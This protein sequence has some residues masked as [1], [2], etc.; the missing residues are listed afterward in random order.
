LGRYRSDRV[1]S[2]RR[3][4][5]KF[6]TNPDL[7]ERGRVQHARIQNALARTLRQYGITPWSAQATG[8]A[9]FD[10]AW[11]WNRALWVGEVKSLTRSN[12]E[13]QL[14]LG[15]GQVLRYHDLL[16]E[17]AAAR[18]VRPWL[19]VER[20]PSDPGWRRLCERHAVALVVPE[21]FAERIAALLSSGT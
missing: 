12:E 14:R 9:S 13:R 19:I 17:S 16:A 18:T 11:L 2:V 21:Q 10:I 7:H 8:D 15:L 4:S 5:R 1:V 6:D 20:E 3:E